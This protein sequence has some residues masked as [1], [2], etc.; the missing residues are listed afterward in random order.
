[1]RIIRAVFLVIAIFILPVNVQAKGFEGKINRTSGRYSL[2]KGDSF[3]L[4]FPE[5]MKPRIAAIASLLEKQTAFVK[6]QFPDLA[7]G[8]PYLL[9]VKN[10]SEISDFDDDMKISGFE[11]NPHYIPGYV[12]ISY[13]TTSQN[14]AFQ[15][16]K[17]HIL[18][19]VNSSKNLWAKGLAI[20]KIPRWFLFSAAMNLSYSQEPFQ[21][22]MVMR[23]FKNGNY[24]SLKDMDKFISEP[25]M[26]QAELLAQGHAMLEFWEKQYG[27]GS[28][29]KIIN[30]TGQGK[31][32]RKS[33]ESVCGIS[34]PQAF[35]EFKEKVSKD[36]DTIDKASFCHFNTLEEKEYL[37]EGE[38]VRSF[39]KI[40]DNSYAWASN[41]DYEQE[42]YDL[43]IKQSG[44]PPKRVAQNIHPFLFASKGKLFFAR[45]ALDKRTV[46]RLFISSCDQYGRKM[47]KSNMPGS[48]YPLA[49][50]D[51]RIYFLSIADYTLSL[52]SAN[53]DN[54][55]DVRQEYHFPAH[56]SPLAFAYDPD[57]RKLYFSQETHPSSS[58]IYSV[59]L[60]DSEP[61]PLKVLSFDSLLRV[62]TFA[63]DSLW[64]VAPSKLV[65]FSLFS[66]EPSKDK[67]TEVLRTAS[68][69]TDISFLGDEL[70]LSALVEKGLRP[71]SCSS[72]EFCE[73]EP[74]EKKASEPLELFTA[75]IESEKTST[76]QDD[77][78]DSYEPYS[79]VLNKEYIRPMVSEDPA[80]KVFGAF[81]IFSDVLGRETFNFAPTY[82]L[83]SRKKGY[84]VRYGKKLFDISLNLSFSNY[85]LKESYLG[86]SYFSERRSINPEIEW[87]LTPATLFTVGADRKRVTS[88]KDRYQDASVPMPSSGRDHSLYFVLQHEY[89]RPDLYSDLLPR[90]GV[91]G[92]IAFARGSPHIFDGEFNYDAL[93]A[94]FNQ[95][96]PLGY[97]RVFSISLKYGRDKKRDGLRRPADLSVGGNDMLMA[98]DDSF[99]SG[100]R[101]KYA[102]VSLAAPFELQAPKFLRFFVSTY[103]FFS[104]F[105]EVGDATDSDFDYARD[106]GAEIQSKILLFR[107][108]PLVLRVGHARALDVSRSNSYFYV[109]FSPLA[110]LFR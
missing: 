48:F 99:R 81:S 44:E 62:M 26:K 47:I 1:M 88:I 37:F 91:K 102:S 61:A 64:F 106:M 109:D 74:E 60:M 46:K 110:Q 55:N 54:F 39:V 9:V 28:M 31:A 15:L 87:V 96:F 57:N 90:K 93:R 65:G 50:H 41:S 6:E 80:G 12:S 38:L 94:S 63:S 58:E 45:L 18:E 25:P 83:S 43:Y 7:A 14:Y 98:F 34:L 76:L 59:D 36:L 20:L 51:G 10:N 49:E 105:F 85:T 82:G 95:Y 16:A 21:K 97:N 22:A 108:M 13:E 17:K 53:F 100:D 24:Y 27:K 66:F 8:Y 29:I 75:N 69:I 104:L 101:L 79:A 56:I 11:L 72:R 42:K 71:C 19:L 89:I 5:A 32:F 30:Q 103:S 40:A 67:L 84:L 4:L 78:S 33:F 23:L 2:Y 3:R 52:L 92:E 86:N 73:F 35:T 70:Y 107:Q 77:L 68:G